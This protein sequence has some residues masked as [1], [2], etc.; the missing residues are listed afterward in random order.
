MNQSLMR[1]CSA[2]ANDISRHSLF[3]RHCGHPQGRPLVVWTLGVFLLMMVA[4]YIALTVY[5][6]HHTQQFRVYGPR[7]QRGVDSTELPLP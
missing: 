7:E 6:A 4:V 2:C 3:C 5:G 1:K